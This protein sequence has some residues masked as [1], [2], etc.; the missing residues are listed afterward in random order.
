MEK[1]CLP[2]L[3]Y[4]IECLNTKSAQMSELNSWWNSIYREIFNYNKWESVKQVI[5]F[6]G[7]LDIHHIVNMRRL[8]FIK[9][10]SLCQNNSVMCDLFKHYLNCHELF[11]LQSLYGSSLFWSAE[12]IKAM[13]YVSFNS[14]CADRLSNS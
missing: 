6:M 7:R 9:R 4:G 3:L 8:H 14:L 12:K 2:V 5:C 11:E 1:Y 13:T 10:V